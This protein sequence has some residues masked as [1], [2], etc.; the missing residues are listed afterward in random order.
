MNLRQ[1][2]ERRIL[3]K[4]IIPSRDGQGPYL[5]RYHLIGRPSHP[6]GQWPFDDRGNPRPGSMK[7][8]GYCYW[9]HNIRRSDSEAELHSHPW[10]W[11][12]SFI[13]WGGYWEERR[14]WDAIVGGWV[15]RQRWVRPWSFNFLR[16][17]TFHRIDVGSKPVWTLFLT[18]P[19]FSKGGW[20]FWD[21]HTG[22]F[23][24]SGDF[25]YLRG[26]RPAS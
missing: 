13:L 11:A 19:A 5:V 16:G 1:W 7:A 20:G 2:I 15:V 4:R 18:A 23:I 9:L 24:P 17:D 8:K 10:P 26:I 25:R 21:R 3:A 12:A 22:R 6:D 14:V